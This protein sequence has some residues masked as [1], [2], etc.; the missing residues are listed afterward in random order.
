MKELCVVRT[1]L[2]KL[3]EEPALAAVATDESAVWLHVCFRTFLDDTEGWGVIL[4]LSASSF[5]TVIAL[6]GSEWV[7]FSR[8]LEMVYCAA[9]TALEIGVEKKNCS[10]LPLD[11]VRIHL[12]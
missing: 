2:T 7:L 1:K 12:G 10:V 5:A 9:V 11:R 8:R 3:F 6:D 4:A